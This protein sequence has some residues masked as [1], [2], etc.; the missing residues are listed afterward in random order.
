MAD[1]NNVALDTLLN[2]LKTSGADAWEV[3]D[4]EEKG[5]EFYFIRHSLD[6]HRVKDV[7]SFS[8][9]VYKKFDDCLGRAEASIPSGR[10][11]RAPSGI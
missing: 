4:E 2:V 5:W 8:V 3:T 10:S 1:M 11:G 7:R 9:S 6:Q